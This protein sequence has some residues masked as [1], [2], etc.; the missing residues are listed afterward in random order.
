MSTVITGRGYV[1]FLSQAE[2]YGKLKKK[3]Q[4]QLSI[5]VDETKLKKKKTFKNNK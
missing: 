4:Q 5:N 1:C 3:K 2:N